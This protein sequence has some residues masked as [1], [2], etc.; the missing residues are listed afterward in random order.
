MKAK[1]FPIMELLT[2][3]S[4]SYTTVAYV[5]NGSLI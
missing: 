3:H 5:L 1:D 4:G 2:M